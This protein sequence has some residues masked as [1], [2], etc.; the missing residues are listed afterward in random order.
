LKAHGLKY[1]MKKIFYI[2]TLGLVLVLG[3]CGNNKEDDNTE[4]PAN[5]NREYDNRDNMDNMDDMDT[6]DTNNGNY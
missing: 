2:T 3:A 6:T 4:S 5:N 1:N